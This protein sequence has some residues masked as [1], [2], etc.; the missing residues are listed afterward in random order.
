ML[1]IFI[2]ELNDSFRFFSPSIV[3]TVDEYDYTTSEK[4]PTY[5]YEEKVEVFVRH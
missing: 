1:C 4:G 2:S 5:E 3:S